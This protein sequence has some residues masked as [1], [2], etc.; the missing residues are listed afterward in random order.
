VARFVAPALRALLEG[1]ID[2]AGAFPPAAL[3]CRNAFRN[4]EEYRVSSHAWIVGRFVVTAKDLDSLLPEAVAPFSVLAERDHARAASIE[5]KTLVKT[6]RPFYWETADLSAVR[7]AGVFAKF[8]TGGLTPDAIPTVDSV[9]EFLEDTARLGVGLKFTAGMHAAIRSERA[10][11]YEA[12]APRAVMHGFVNIFLAAA[13]IWHGIGIARDVLAETDPD[14]FCFDDRAHWRGYSLTG[15][16][17]AFARRD[18]VHSF[19]SCS[20]LEPL[21]SLQALNW[22][23]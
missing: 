3:P 10:L 19:G 4:Y 11:T 22:V 12:N 15:Q 13:F 21:E 18:F 5:S 1:A 20:F 23:A 6:T 14:A 7:R 16:Q 17:I 8:R 9:A 2:Y